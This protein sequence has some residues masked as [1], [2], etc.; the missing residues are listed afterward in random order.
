[1][2]DKQIIIYETITGRQP[3]A[4]WLDALK[5]RRG[6]AVIRARLNRLLFGNFGDCKSVGNGI[7]ELRI[8]FGPGYRVYFGYEAETVVILLC[9]GDKSSQKR[10]VLLAR[11]YWREYQ[12]ANSR[13]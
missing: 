4:E 3:F 6:R 2:S 9:G 11:K 5:D 7:F 12:N 1:M 13:I 10:D 8:F